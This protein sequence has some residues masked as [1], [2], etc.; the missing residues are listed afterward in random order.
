MNQ[1][2]TEGVNALGIEVRC[3]LR[4]HRAGVLSTHS[5]RFEGYPFGSVIPFVLDHEARP[6]FLISS[7]AEHYRNMVADRKVS[8][9]VQDPSVSDVQ[10]A[11]RLTIVGDATP[12]T[13][14]V[15]EYIRPRYLRYFPNS[16][17]LLEL[18]DFSF[19]GLAP[20]SIRFVGGFGKINWV[21]ASDFRPQSHL[22]AQIEETLLGEMSSEQCLRLSI[23][24]MPCL[25]KRTPD[26][27]LLGVDCDG[28]DLLTDAGQHRI[29]F[30]RSIYSMDDIRR[31]IGR[32]TSEQYEN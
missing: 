7:L 29:N 14:E 2:N 22:P 3:F 23:G 19:W 26:A 1:R 9:L 8:L 15:M 17:R 10:V 25:E 21:S 20:V 6:V 4:K 31:E 13:T 30:S 16:S 5:K 11:A 32:L 27:R 24:S 28:L 12:V 18:G